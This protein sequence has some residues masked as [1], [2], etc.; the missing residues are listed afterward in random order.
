MTQARA[1]IWDLPTRVFHWMLALSFGG[2]WLAF[3]DDRY[4]YIHVYSGYVLLALLVFR[5]LWGMIGSHYARFFSFAHS[6]PSATAYLKA[7][8]T[9]QAA[10]YVGHNPA[11]SWAIFLMLLLGIAVTV[12]GM[13]TLGGEERH[14]LFVGLMTIGT[15]F[16]FHEIHEVLAWVM[17]AV[18]ALHL[19]GVIVESLYHRENLIM[20]MITGYKEGGD[21]GVQVRP[22]SVVAVV[23]MAAIVASSFITFRGYLSQTEQH[24]FLPFEGIVLPDNATWR[25]ECGDCHMAYHP[26]L[27]PA[28]SWVALMNGQHDH[29]GDD[30]DL[31]DD[32]KTEITEFLVRNSAEHLLVEPSWRILTETPDNETPLRVTETHYW[33]RKHAEIEQRYWDSKKVMSKGNCPACHKDARAGT[34]EDADMHLPHL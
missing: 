31:D 33:K 25:E 8:L 15:G 29:F 9:G 23:L 12:T 21:D 5:L 11:G 7:L 18:V 30:L 24:P 13:L 10:R 14:G 1:L 19:V 20:A 28:R 22:G 32:D 6:W 4:L 3:D 34:Y 27:L 2:A 26:S 17:L 16:V